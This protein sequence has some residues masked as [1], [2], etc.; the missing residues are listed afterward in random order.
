MYQIYYTFLNEKLPTA[1]TF[2]TEAEAK[3]RV[4]W[5]NDNVQLK[6]GKYIYEEE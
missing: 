6:I 2:E 4:K 5:L 3:E 1:I